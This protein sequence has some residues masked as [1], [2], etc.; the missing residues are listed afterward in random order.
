MSGT[1]AQFH[2][3]QANTSSKRG[4]H[5]EALEAVMLVLRRFVWWSYLLHA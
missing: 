4:S 5:Q 3:Y 1:R 2:V